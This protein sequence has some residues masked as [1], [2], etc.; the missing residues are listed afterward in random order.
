MKKLFG[1][2]FEIISDVVTR[3]I[4]LFRNNF[5]IISVFPFTRNH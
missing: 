3:E 5:E 2:N 4:E 1:N